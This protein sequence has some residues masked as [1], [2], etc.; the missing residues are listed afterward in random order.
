[1]LLRASVE[2]RLD[3]GPA[4]KAHFLLASCPVGLVCLL[5]PTQWGTH[6]LQSNI[7][8]RVGKN[9]SGRVASEGLTKARGRGQSASGGSAVLQAGNGCR[10]PELETRDPL[11]A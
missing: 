10:H 8:T 9:W 5:H 7:Q 2:R 1:M 3:H 6:K 11:G 4:C